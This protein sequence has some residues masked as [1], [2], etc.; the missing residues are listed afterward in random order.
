VNGQH[1]I[2]E[3]G[4][5]KQPSAL[6]EFIKGNFV[7]LLIVLALVVGYFL[8]RNTPSGVASVEELRAMSDAGRPVLVEFYSN[9]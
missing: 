8:L 3:Q 7:A 2:A 4:A 5:V 9:T 6:L 1:R